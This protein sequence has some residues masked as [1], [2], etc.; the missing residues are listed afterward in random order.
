MVS[1]Y[2]VELRTLTKEFSRLFRNRS[3]IVVEDV[4]LNIGKGEIFG[5]LGP[6]G[7][8]KTTIVKM[9]CGLIRPTRGEILING[10]RLDRNRHV[11]T[12]IGA[13][14][15]GSRNSLWS[16]TV[17]QNLTYFGHL[18]HVHGR[19]LKER[20]DALLNLFQL[21]Q[22]R[23]DVVRNLSKGMKQKLAI[24][25]AFIA[26]PD[27]ILLDEPT[28]GLDI[29]GA[30]LVKEAIVR[31]AKLENKTVLLTTHQLDIVEE[32]CDRV[33]IIHKG[34]LIALDRTEKLCNNFGREHYDVKLQGRPDTVFLKDLPIFR[35]VEIVHGDAEKEEFLVRFVMDRE[36]SLFEAI[37][38][39]RRGGV[40]ILSMTK[41]EPKLEDVFVKMV[42]V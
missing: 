14:L 27:I 10:Q 6:N 20:C 28:L 41:V 24:V 7:A 22:K 39:L 15:E 18:K 12:R 38:A 42:D 26:D 36:D 3:V 5:L 21:E 23:D 32:I 37:D 8:G 17:R 29:H 13:V 34:R 11:L 40:R 19:V 1:M 35:N 2:S 31:L 4:N 16:M 33:A 9:I 25:L 30:R